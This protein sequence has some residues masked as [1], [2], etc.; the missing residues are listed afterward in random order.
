MAAAGSDEEAGG[1]NVLQS[2]IEIVKKLFHRIDKGF[3][4]DIV[5]SSFSR[6]LLGARG[7]F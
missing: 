2:N 3:S 7:G 1:A 5:A 4:S 6:F